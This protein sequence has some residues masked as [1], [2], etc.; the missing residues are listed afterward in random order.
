MTS[1]DIRIGDIMATRQPQDPSRKRPPER[2][3]QSKAR[4]VP[5]LRDKKMNDGR[6]EMK[7]TGRFA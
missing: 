5:P 6:K 3:R 2:L 7:Q 1:L 4:Q